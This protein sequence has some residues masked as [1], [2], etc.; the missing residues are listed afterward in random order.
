MIHLTRVDRLYR[1]KY[2]TMHFESTSQCSLLGLALRWA[3][4]LSFST[5]KIVHYFLT[6]PRL[7]AFCPETYPISPYYY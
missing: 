1:A 7:V 2:H 6:G 3:G 4:Q 5:R